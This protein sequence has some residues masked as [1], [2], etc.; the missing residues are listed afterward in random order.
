MART[1]IAVLIVVSLLT[2][3]PVSVEANWD[4][5]GGG[6]AYNGM[7]SFFKV[8]V[9]NRDRDDGVRT[10]LLVTVDSEDLHLS[11]PLDWQNVL[12][13]RAMYTHPYHHGEEDTVLETEAVEVLYGNPATYYFGI[14]PDEECETGTY[15]VNIGVQAMNPDGTW[16]IVE[17]KVLMLRVEESIEVVLPR[18]ELFVG[19][20]A[21]KIALLVRNRGRA[22]EKIEEVSATFEVLTPECDGQLLFCDLTNRPCDATE[23]RFRPQRKDSLVNTEDNPI[24]PYTIRVDERFRCD[25]SEYCGMCDIRVNVT[26]ITSYTDLLLKRSYSSQIKAD[27]LAPITVR[28]GERSDV[29]VRLVGARAQD[30]ELHYDGIPG[31]DLEIPLLIKNTGRGYAHSCEA[32][33]AVP[34]FRGMAAYDILQIVSP[35]EGQAVG[36]DLV[37]DG[38]VLDRLAPDELREVRYVLRISP[39]AQDNLDRMPVFFELECMDGFGR[40]YT[41]EKDGG[42]DDFY[43][44][45]SRPI[46]PELALDVTASSDVIDGD[47]FNVDITLTNM[48]PTPAHDCT[49]SASWSGPV[50]VAGDGHLSLSRQLGRDTP[51]SRVMEFTVVVS[52]DIKATW[53]GAAPGSIRISGT[54]TAWCTDPRGVSLATTSRSLSIAVRERESAF[55]KRRDR[56][57]ASPGRSWTSPGTVEQDVVDVEDK[58]AWRGILGLGVLVVFIWLIVMLNHLQRMMS[59]PF[60]AVSDE[61]RDRKM[62]DKESSDE[63][64]DEL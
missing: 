51:Y 49:L 18:M 12:L 10:S 50:P 5:L 6:K 29:H 14:E 16:A 36:E 44:T 21:K 4:A 22:V 55:M 1:I 28:A 27:G 48:A 35:F 58:L 52:E 25:D 23:W 59:A 61:E 60:T 9:M 8:T 54:F 39:D 37:S 19:G 45:V 63:D 34:S 32:L 46:P 26:Y 47:P 2:T 41:A 64:V 31:E 11:G 38:V 3:A 30:G 42:W 20:E 57:W 15:R 43:I 40:Q 7:T 53:Q 62:R 13:K 56:S 33:I 17:S 24:I